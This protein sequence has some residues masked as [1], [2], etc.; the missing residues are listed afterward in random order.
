MGN[1]GAERVT[2][3]QGPCSASGS[4]PCVGCKE[5]LKARET[6]LCATGTCAGYKQQVFFFWR[7]LPSLWNSPRRGLPGTFAACF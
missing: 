1:L 3:L 7:A 4:V 5:L 2:W 6:S